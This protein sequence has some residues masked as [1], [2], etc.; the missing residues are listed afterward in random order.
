MPELQ[1]FFYDEFVF[2][3]IFLR[4]SHSLASFRKFSFTYILIELA[5]RHVQ[6]DASLF[7]RHHLMRE[8]VDDIHSLILVDLAS[9]SVNL[10]GCVSKKF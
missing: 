3:E 8:H 9:A 1:L 5:S 4:K 7:L 10:V 6:I 2:I